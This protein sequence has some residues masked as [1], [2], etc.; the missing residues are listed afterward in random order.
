MR[1]LIT[2]IL[3]LLSLGAQASTTVFGCG[4]SGLETSA[5]CD[6]H[7]A[8]RCPSPS[9][10]RLSCDQACSTDAVGAVA[11]TV[12]RDQ[13]MPRLDPIDGFAALATHSYT[14]VASANFPE[15]AWQSVEPPAA[16][17]PSN[18]TYLATA[19]LRL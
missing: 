3:M 16:R 10:A 19:R 15:R 17:Y 8:H 2:V 9:L 13:Q 1:Q 6:P 12:E 18:P 5:C 4:P 7:A 11:M 14:L